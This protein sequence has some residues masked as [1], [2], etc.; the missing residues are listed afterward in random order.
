MKRSKPTEIQ[1][2]EDEISYFAAKVAV[3]LGIT[4]IKGAKKLLK[5]YE[6]NNQFKQ[7]PNS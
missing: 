7:I 2:T 3:P 4:T 6:K 5:E 1:W